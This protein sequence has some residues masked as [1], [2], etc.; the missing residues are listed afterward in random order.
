[1]QEFANELP[2]LFDFVFLVL[3]LALHLLLLLNVYR[4]FPVYLIICF[5]LLVGQSL[6]KEVCELPYLFLKLLVVQY[7]TGSHGRSILRLL[8]RSIVLGVINDRTASNC[9]NLRT[10]TFKLV[11]TSALES[12][13]WPIKH[14]VGS[15][16]VKS[17][18]ASIT[19]V[20]CLLVANYT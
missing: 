6:F 3:D 20:V 19:L 18:V 11:S 12:V 2:L 7:F 14:L 10:F 15:I 1:M 16:A 13:F 5:S 4:S 8:N 9:V 17:L